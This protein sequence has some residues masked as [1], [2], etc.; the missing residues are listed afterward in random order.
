MKRIIVLALLALSLQG[1]SQKEEGQKGFDPDR[2]FFGGDI[3][4]NISSGITAI[5][6][7]PLVGYRITDRWSAGVGVTYLYYSVDFGLAGKYSTSIYGGN[8]FTRVF[9]IDNIFAQTEFHI[10]NTDAAEYDPVADEVSIV[11]RN[12][13]LWYVGGG[14]RIPMGGNAFGAITG[15]WDLIDDPYSPYANPNIRI[16]FIFGL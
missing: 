1:T 9:V 3:T 13:P 16:G 4:L 6:A 8:V 14:V 15:M 7:S 5:G 2:L 10:V 11:R 12:V